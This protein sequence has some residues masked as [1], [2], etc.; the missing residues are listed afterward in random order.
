LQTVW[1]RLVV[2]L[3]LVAVVGLCLYVPSYIVVTGT[4]GDIT[5][6]GP[7]HYGWVWNLGGES[8]ISGNTVKMLVNYGLLRLE[9]GFLTAIAGIVF[10]N[11]W[12]NAGDGQ[13]GRRPA[14]V[15]TRIVVV[16]YLV[17]VAGVCQFDKEGRLALKV[18]SLPPAIAGVLFLIGSFV[19]GR[20]R[21]KQSDSST[22]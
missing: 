6:S 7:V 12:K 3:Y 5:A 1:T 4:N 11:I 20:K 18:V 17:A 14:P 22:L 13:Y 15:W 2:V 10:Y 16:L 21:G 9:V 8:N 19:G